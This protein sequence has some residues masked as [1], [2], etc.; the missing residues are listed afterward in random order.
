MENILRFETV[1][2]YN[3][4]NN[5][6]TLYPLVSVIDYSKADPSNDSWM[7]F[8]LYSVVLKDVDC[9]DIRYGKLNYDYQKGTLVF[10]TP[11]QIIGYESHGEYH[12][13]KGMGLVF[14]PDL[15]HGTHLGKHMKDYSFFTYQSNE[16]LHLSEDEKGIVMD[17]F[18]K[19]KFELEHA[20]DKHS[21][22]IIVSNIELFLN[23]VNRFYDRQFILRERVNSGILVSFEKLLDDYFDSENPSAIGLPAVCWCASQ[24]NLSSNYFGDLVKKHTGKSA[25]EYIQ[26][27]VIEVAKS[28]IYDSEKS[29]SQIANEMGFRYPSSFT[30]FFKQHVGFTPNE[31]RNLN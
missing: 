7:F 18:S 30:R 13:P 11:G 21:K 26:S 8:G 23:H 19:I 3:E 29:L 20:I 12:Q 27:K 14:H 6:K 2:R 16:A 5:Q 15:L 25:Q 24:L 1:S 9:G 4:Y 31:F 17:C 10:F 28:K 22:N